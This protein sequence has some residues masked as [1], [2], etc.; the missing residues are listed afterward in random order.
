MGDRPTGVVTFVFTDIEGST[1][2]LRA[3]GEAYDDVLLEHR[4]LIRAAFS[5]HGGRE[6]DTQGDA[7]FTAFER[8]AGAVTA[9]A[10]AQRAIG[11]HAWPEGARLRVRMGVHSSPARSGPE[12][13]V[14]LGVHRGARI[15][16][17]AHGGQVLVSRSTRELLEDD[18][19]PGLEFRDLGDHRLKDLTEPQRLYQLLGQGLEA[20]FPPPRTLDVRRTNL[21]VQPTPL[22]GRQREVRELCDLIAGGARLVTLTGPGGSGKTRLALQAGAEL[23]DGCADGVFFVGLGAIEDPELVKQTIAQTLGLPASGFQTLEGF[24]GD[25]DLLLVLDN[26]EQ[27]LDAASAVVA[28][29]RDAQS[30]K[31]LVTSRALLRVSGERSY[32]V[33]PLGLPDPSRG[34][35]PGTLAECESVTLFV[36]RARSVQPGF[37]LTPANAAAVGRICLDLDG[38]PLAIELAAARVR[39]LSPEAMLERLDRRLHLLTGGPR[40]AE[41]RQRTLRATLEWSYGLL[42]PDEQ[43]VFAA[44]GVFQGGF[45]LDAAEGVASAGLDE[46]EGLVDH[47]LL[48]EDAG[49]FAMLETVREYAVERLDADEA[50]QEVRRRHAEF[51]NDLAEHAYD[52]RLVEEAEWLD[53][54]ELEHDNLR[55]ALDRLEASPAEELRLAGALGWFWRDHSHLQEG[56]RRLDHALNNGAAD[57]VLRARALTADGALAG[58]SGDVEGARRHLTEATR[59]WEELGEYQELGLALHALGWSEVYNGHDPEARAAFERSLAILREVGNPKLVNRALVG[60]C[61]VLV[62]QGDVETAVPLSLE[63]LD[64]AVA[65][66]DRSSEHFALHFLGDCALLTEDYPEAE[67]RYV[68]SLEAAWELG[69]RLETCFEIQGVGMAAAG[70]DRPRR[71]LRLM[72]AGGEL[73]AELGFDVASVPFW[74]RL[75]DQH[76]ERARGQLS[77]EDVEAVLTA[78]R[79]PTL[80]QAVELGLDVTRDE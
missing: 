59:L 16:S 11:Q 47:S 36:D 76:L 28:L 17:A 35:D 72:G 74:K 77:Q 21:P 51:F 9:A 66:G 3:L 22:I 65:H 31:V 29:L 50:E 48:R 26:F 12:G 24:L 2:L 53:R 60:I 5:Q 67:A 55:A 19:P 43:R 45:T 8:P 33:R 54:L 61:Q 44:L 23:L 69:D 58:L 40:D 46:L 10:E 73:L 37:A 25:R 30:L 14:G 27:I 39:L 64:L 6:I 15:C 63:A 38:L 75:L 42:A 18:P 41:A 1:V 4:A 68:K 20:D 56:R 49:R 70:L 78:G 7:V 52:R 34:W 79:A 32:P 62:S 13:Y 57:A 80:A 71:A